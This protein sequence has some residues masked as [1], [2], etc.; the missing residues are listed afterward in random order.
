MNIKGI[1][2]GAI[3][4]CTTS[5]V[6]KTYYIEDAIYQYHLHL[7][8]QPPCPGKW[9]LRAVRMNTWNYGRQLRCSAF[10]SKD[11]PTNPLPWR[12]KLTD[13]LHK[14]VC[15]SA[16][17]AYLFSH[18]WANLALICLWILPQR[19][20]KAAFISGDVL[21]W[22]ANAWTGAGSLAVKLSL[23]KKKFTL[24]NNFLVEY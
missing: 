2:G 22:R 10:K 24:R 7:V 8:L 4:I 14:G 5:K 9:N 18:Q 12:I 20:L 23:S 13:Y 3:D 17:A 15:S 16:T 19:I 11:H 1:L 6:I 21:H